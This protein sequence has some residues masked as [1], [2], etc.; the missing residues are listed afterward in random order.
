M[1][2]VLL[3]MRPHA[4]G[5]GWLPMQG[6]LRHGQLNLHLKNQHTHTSS[7]INCVPHPDLLDMHTNTLLQKLSYHVC[8]YSHTQCYHAA[9]FTDFYHLCLL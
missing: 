7:V 3:P 1:P 4:P 9:I 6:Q 2:L 8:I 5:L